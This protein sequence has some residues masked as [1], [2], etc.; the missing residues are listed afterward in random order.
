MTLCGTGNWHGRSHRKCSALEGEKVG[1][2]GVLDGEKRSPKGDE[3][4]MRR[5]Q[6]VEESGRC[7]GQ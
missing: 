3:K 1:K 2:E 4:G 5:A 7:G 6:L